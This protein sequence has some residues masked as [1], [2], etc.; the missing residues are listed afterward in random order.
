MVNSFDLD[1]L[2]TDNLALSCIG[3]EMCWWCD[4]DVLLCVS[5]RS[6]KELVVSYPDLLSTDL[7]YK[8][9]NDNFSN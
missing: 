5:P 3:N 9:S 1:L 8:I 4:D 6:D 7:K 2:N